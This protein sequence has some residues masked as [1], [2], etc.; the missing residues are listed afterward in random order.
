MLSNM[1]EKKYKNLEEHAYM[2]LKNKIKLK[3][4]LPFERIIE[5]NIAEELNMSRTPV[6]RAIQKLEQNNFV[7]IESNK[8]AVVNPPFIDR[9]KYIQRV[10]FI[11]LIFIHVINHVEA[12]SIPIDIHHFSNKLVLMNDYLEKKDYIHFFAIERTFIVEF[13]ALA[14]NDYMTEIVSQ[15]HIDLVSR[16]NEDIKGV[17]ERNTTQMVPRLMEVMRSM[18]TFDFMQ[19][20]KQ[21]RTTINHLLLSA[22]R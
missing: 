11:E 10:E 8:G 7:T 21:V 16:C 15:T 4:I 19:A 3:E 17:M 12:K 20:R 14:Q 5:L 6:R 9:E 13:V 18:D 1:G 22:I 2:Y